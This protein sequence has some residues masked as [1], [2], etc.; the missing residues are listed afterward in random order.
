MFKI[1]LI[2]LLVFKALLLHSLKPM[3]TAYQTIP[4]AYYTLDSV[5]HCLLITCIII[6]I[7]IP[8]V[9]LLSPFYRQ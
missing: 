2:N 4:R 5:Y 7:K 6:F 9:S 1:K 8:T 3:I